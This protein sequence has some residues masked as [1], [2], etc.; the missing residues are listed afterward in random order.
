[1]KLDLLIVENI[2]IYDYSTGSDL[3][4]CDIFK[5][6]TVDNH[7]LFMQIFPFLFTHM[8]LLIHTDINIT[9]AVN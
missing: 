1:M 7:T 9:I 6:Q 3:I 2:A 5:T 4:D 8:I